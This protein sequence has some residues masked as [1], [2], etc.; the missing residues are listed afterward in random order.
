MSRFLE[1]AVRDAVVVRERVV[2]RLD[3][4]VVVLHV[5]DAVRLSHRVHRLLA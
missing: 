4:V 1:P 5:A 3:A 2:D